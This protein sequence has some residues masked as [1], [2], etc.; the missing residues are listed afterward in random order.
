M[1]LE[2][3]RVTDNA[4]N[5]QFN[6]PARSFPQSRAARAAR[7]SSRRI[8]GGKKDRSDNLSTEKYLSYRLCNSVK[9]AQSPSFSPWREESAFH[10]GFPPLFYPR[11]P[12][13]PLLPSY[14]FST[15]AS[16]VLP[17]IQWATSLHRATMSLINRNQAKAW[18]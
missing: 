2:L 17:P 9:R 18:R 12:P 14:S 7:V 3:I 5:E 11:H 10:L 16:P 1:R 6:S 15:R 13:I 8:R 4:S